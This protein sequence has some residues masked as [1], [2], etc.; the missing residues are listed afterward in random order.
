MLAR[1]VILIVLLTACQARL[2]PCPTFE[3][4]TFKQRSAHKTRTALVAKANE[5]TDVKI[6]NRANP[7]TKERF[8][9]NISVEEWD[10][11]EPGK[12]KYM[13]RS[14]RQNIRKNWKKINASDS[15][16]AARLLKD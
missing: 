13:P 4:A 5:K 15:L 1:L 3:T 14:V 2:I 7:K 10:C 6:P 9:R 11:P 16:R 8:V 12:R